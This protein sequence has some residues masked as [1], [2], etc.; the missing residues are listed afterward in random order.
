MTIFCTINSPSG[1]LIRIWEINLNPDR[2]GSAIPHFKLEG[3]GAWTPQSWIRH[4]HRTTYSGQDRKT[5]LLEAGE[6]V[7]EHAEHHL[8]GLRRQVG[9]EENLVGR[10]VVHTAHTLGRNSRTRGARLETREKKHWS[11][12]DTAI[13]LSL[14]AEFVGGFSSL[15]HIH[16]LISLLTCLYIML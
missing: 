15:C 3:G 4:C 11:G 9:E 14:P 10:R 6:L 12:I 2:S 5:D 7:E 1:L 13:F 16:A 8:V